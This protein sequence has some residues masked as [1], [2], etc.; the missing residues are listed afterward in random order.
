MR[1]DRRRRFSLAERLLQ[2][3]FTCLRHSARILEEGKPNYDVARRVAFCRS[4]RRRSQV[5]VV[6]LPA[7]CMTERLISR[8][9]RDDESPSRVHYRARAHPPA[10]L[11]ARPLRFRTPHSD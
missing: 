8:L 10:R 7:L 1:F 11:S 6:T 3:L 2:R 5:V 9:A 4:A